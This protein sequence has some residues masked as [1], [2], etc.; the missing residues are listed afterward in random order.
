MQATNS[1]LPIDHPDIA[2]LI[3]ELTGQSETGSCFDSAMEQITRSRVLELPADAQYGAKVTISLK[4]EAEHHTPEEWNWREMLDLDTDE[5]VRVLPKF[6]GL[7]D[8]YLTLNATRGMPVTEWNWPAIVGIHSGAE[9]QIVKTKVTSV[10]DLFR[11][12]FQDFEA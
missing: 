4:F 9:A 8:L 1:Y 11:L 12:F 6:E 5:H 10:P 3:P 2:E 7:V